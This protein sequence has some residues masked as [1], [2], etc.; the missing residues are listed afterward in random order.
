VHVCLVYV[1]VVDSLD[2]VLEMTTLTL[3]LF[4]LVFA[5]FLIVLKAPSNPN[6]LTDR[7]MACIA[8]HIV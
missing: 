5:V 7:V 3:E 6:H 2:C 4:A 8:S 1:D